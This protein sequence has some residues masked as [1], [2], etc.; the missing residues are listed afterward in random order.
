[1]RQP[2]GF[3]FNSTELPGRV[4]RDDALSSAQSYRWRLNIEESVASQLISRGRLI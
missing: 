3:A 2:R 1:M 4:Y